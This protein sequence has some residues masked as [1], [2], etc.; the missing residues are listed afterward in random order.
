MNNFALFVCGLVVALISG[1]GILVYMVSVGYKK[2]QVKA[3]P[4]FVEPLSSV[5][6]PSVS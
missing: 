5:Q 6:I 1:L 3:V 2:Q 4:K